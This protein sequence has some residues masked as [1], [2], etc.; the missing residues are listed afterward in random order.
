MIKNLLSILCVATLSPSLYARDAQAFSVVD[1]NRIETS[2][3]IDGLI[4]YSSFD[5]S[6]QTLSPAGIITTPDFARNSEAWTSDLKKVKTGEPRFMPGKYG[7][8][9]LIER[10]YA[11]SDR[12]A[13]KNLLP[14]NPFKP[15]GESRITSIKGPGGAFCVKVSGKPPGCLIE[16]A[17]I[18]E[19]SK[20]IK[21]LCFSVYLKGMRNQSATIEVIDKKHAV[22]M[23]SEWCRAEIYIPLDDAKRNLCIKIYLETDGEFFAVAPML[24]ILGN[25]YS[26]TSTASSW[27]PPL[28]KRPGE[29]LK[30]RLPGTL[31]SGTVS[32]WFKLCGKN[33]C[34]RLLSFDNSSGWCPVISV[35]I[36][37]ERILRL[38]KKQ[39]VLSESLDD[40]K[41]HHVVL[42]WKNGLAELFLDNKKYLE[43]PLSPL[44]APFHLGGTPNDSSP[45]LRA[46][47]LFD[48]LSIWN[49]SLPN[50][51]ISSLYNLPASLGRQLSCPLL[52]HDLEPISVFCRDQSERVWKLELINNSGD[53]L[54]DPILAWGIDGIFRKTR[55]LKSL[56]ANSSLA[57]D[58]DWQPVMLLPGKY[59][60]F[61]QV[62]GLNYQRDIEIRCART[63]LDNIQ[64]RLCGGEDPEYGKLGVTMTETMIDSAQI[65]KNNRS[66]LYSV[67]RLFV[68]GEAE[69]DQD[70]MLDILGK[71]HHVD[72]RAPVPMTSIKKQAEKL[73]KHLSRFPDIREIVMNSEN[74]WVWGLDFR[75]ET[76]KMAK[77][78]FDLDLNKWRDCPENKRWRAVPP[79]GR[80]APS[81]GGIHRPAKGIVPLRDPLYAFLRWWHSDQAGNEVFLN[82]LVANIVRRHA[83]WLKS[84]GEPALR[85]PA[86]RVFKS[87]DI[88]D[89]WFYYENP[90]VAIYT[91]ERLT[92]AARGT[93]AQISG[94]PQFLFKAGKA[95]PF[96]AMP[97]P[98]LFREAMWLCLSR[99][100]CRFDLWGMWMALHPQKGALEYD[101]LNQEL[102]RRLDG[103][104]LNYKNVKEVVNTR[105]EHSDISLFIPE[106]R[107]EI[108]Y[109]LNKIV[110]PLGA[111]LPRW[112]NKTR[113]IAV[114]ISFA[115]QIY[116]EIRWP[117]SPPVLN[118]LS[119]PYDVLYDQD[120]EDNPDVLRDY[121]VVVLQDCVAVTAPAA[122]QL[123]HFGKRGGL[124]IAD[125]TYRC[126]FDNVIVL[127]YGK[128]NLVAEKKMKEKHHELLRLFKD[129]RHPQYIEGMEQIA[130]ELNA[131]SVPF[132]YVLKLVNERLKPTINV[133]DHHVKLNL[134]EASGA[135]Y[136]VAVNDLRTYGKYFGPYRRVLEKG[137]PL[138]DV[139]FDI[140]RQNT[141]VAYELL[142]CQEMVMRNSKLK[143]DLPPGGGKIVMFLPEYLDRLSLDVQKYSH[144]GETVPIKVVLSGKSGKLPPGLIPVRLDIIR[145]DGSVDSLSRNS[146]IENGKFH[147][148]LPIPFNAPLGKWQIMIRELASG[149]TS[150][151][152]L[153]IKQ[154]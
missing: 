118:D 65:E 90:L 136:L 12:N 59:R 33:S 128:R 74:T 36:K 89:E 63:P 115:G 37:S 23:A 19:K 31:E 127:D 45:G 41:W 154:Q 123:E 112:K 69:S 124:L 120:F 113:K 70:L 91:Q 7:Q 96:K 48:E 104:E 47:S 116:S 101:E 27:M 54:I 51:E 98:H 88:L 53:E 67:V 131:K 3:L 77:E 11:G 2:E 18:P 21:A 29:R 61:A 133:D 140:P 44:N 122:I 46:D 5:N 83:P 132:D 66:R 94:Q 58:L 130:E 15:L 129:A 92:A 30:Y 105:G 14:R 42:R 119:Y 8:S 52:I 138:S 108:D 87:Q 145:P 99:P 6:I 50:E 97:A 34:R 10:G 153:E 103:K 43:S 152:T 78:K 117:G 141:K 35:D 72:Q 17:A 75:P 150:R 85:R 4:Q 16:S 28:R 107:E 49:R 38:G 95:A 139:T 62:L 147:F 151:K 86:V 135:D 126:D 100:L 55:H 146:V 110:H 25:H 137:I 56:P 81:I 13:G 20:K 111:L 22:K 71:P 114:Y 60:F 121:E 1:M 64:V 39:K 26:I 57:I 76:I 134:L 102:K 68:H 80:L 40:E 143:L 79:F 82:D 149:K 144:P 142:N 24:E 148:N 109:M 84:I 93:R 9:L 106:L 32:C 125:Q 73:G